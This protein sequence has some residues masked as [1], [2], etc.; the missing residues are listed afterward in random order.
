MAHARSNQKLKRSFRRY[1]I[2]HLNA[3]MICGTLAPYVLSYEGQER[4]RNSL[5]MLF[6]LLSHLDSEDLCLSWQAISD[7]VGQAQCHSTL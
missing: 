1:S 7:P 2:L 3:S 5:T 4:E 6:A